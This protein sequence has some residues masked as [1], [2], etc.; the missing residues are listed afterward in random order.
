MILWTNHE[1]QQD[2]ELSQAIQ[3]IYNEGK[4]SDILRYLILLRL[5]GVYMDVDY[6]FV[7]CLEAIP[8]LFAIP[9]GTTSSSSSSTGSGG[10][11]VKFFCGLSNTCMVEVNNGILG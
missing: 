3:D 10:Q 4:A 11:V 2:P 1:I 7:G 5:G 6:E 9:I 8:G